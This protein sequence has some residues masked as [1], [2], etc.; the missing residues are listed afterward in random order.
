M[1]AAVVPCPDIAP[2]AP[3]APSCTT[4]DHDELKASPER[5]AALQLSGYQGFKQN[6]LELRLCPRCG[7]CL[8]RMVKVVAVEYLDQVHQV[9]GARVAGGA[10]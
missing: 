5:W 6:T 10:A 7:S 4:Q 1:V 9:E 8:A 3:A 2:A